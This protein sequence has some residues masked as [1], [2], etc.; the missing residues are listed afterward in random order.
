[1]EN[2]MIPHDVVTR[3][4]DGTLPVQAWREHLNLTQDEVAERMGVSQSAF[5]ELESVSKPRKQTREKIAAAFGI[6]AAQLEL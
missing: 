5:A 2:N 3:I 1:M 6:N 4:V